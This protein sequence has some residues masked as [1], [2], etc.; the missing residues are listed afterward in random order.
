MISYY[1]PE[2]ICKRH[3][4]VST[5]VLSM[6]R[7]VGNPSLQSP[8]PSFCWDPT[9]TRWYM[10]KVFIRLGQSSHL[11]LAFGV[12]LGLVQILKTKWFYSCCNLPQEICKRYSLIETY[13]KFLVSR[14]FFAR[15]IRH[16]LKFLFLLYPRH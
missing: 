11:E 1:K 14:P 9:S 16:P 6:T 5:V 15:V 8:T 12:K 7:C 3:T 13:Q 2:V 10:V 4:L